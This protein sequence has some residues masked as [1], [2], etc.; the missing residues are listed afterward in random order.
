[1]K[2]ET[3]SQNRRRR[4]TWSKAPAPMR[5][6]LW[7]RSALR[8]SSYQRARLASGAKQQEISK[9]HATGW[10]KPSKGPC[11]QRIIGSGKQSVRHL[12]NDDEN[13]VVGRL[14]GGA[15]ALLL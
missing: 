15:G 8:A 10:N 6:T 2:T 7:R 12:V 5:V 1:M 9:T 13:N 3:W 4:A 14:A 11:R